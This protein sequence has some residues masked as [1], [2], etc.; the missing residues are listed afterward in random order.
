MSNLS[1]YIHYP[2]CLSKCPYCDFN[3]YKLSKLDE[4]KFLLAYL[5][6]LEYY[7]NFFKNKK[8][9]TI[10]FGGGTPSLMSTKFLESILE[11]ISNLWN[12]NN[13]AEISMEANPTTF[14]IKKFQ[15]LKYIGI[16]RLS[17]GIQSLDD[18]VLKFFGRLHNAKESIEAINIANKVF[19]D[20]YSI[21]MI[22]CRPQQKLKNWLEELNTAIKLS[23]FHISLYQLMIEE[24]T[25]FFNDGIKS[26]NENKAA[27]MY[28]ITND[29]M[30]NNGIYLYEVSNYSKKG[31]ECK[32][33]LNYWNSGEWIGIG[34]GAHSRLC[35][36]ENFINGYKIRNSIEN[37]KNPIK[38]Q[39]NVLLYGNG[40]NTKEELNKT[41]FIEEILL[42]GLRTKTGIYTNNINKYL[43]INTIKDI[44]NKRYTNFLKYINICDDY[45]KVKLEYF[46]ILDSII[47]KFL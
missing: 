4:E 11:K 42:M 41:E 30:E 12:I 5:K 2:F 37:I 9:N 45:I 40:C 43:K 16:N 14:E 25:K 35:F 36:D 33:N 7:W 28:K 6:E 26:L 23:P 29:F 3:S 27:K 47:E 32:H 24:N 34:A 46:N 17:I 13:D 22:Y 39:N 44:L 1:I 8:I 10:F 18:N 38:W 19:V 31:Y 15:E 20:K 21:D